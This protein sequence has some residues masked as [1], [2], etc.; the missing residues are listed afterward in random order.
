MSRHGISIQLASKVS[1]F[2][3]LPEVLG[4]CHDPPDAVAIGINDA[5]LRRI[6]VNL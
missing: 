6:P 2:L 3:R 1:D 4:L 5:R